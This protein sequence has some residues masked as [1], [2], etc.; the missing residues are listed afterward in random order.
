M[1]LLPDVILY[2]LQ[3]LVPFQLIFLLHLQTVSA[4]IPARRPAA[5]KRY[6]ITTKKVKKKI[7]KL[8]GNWRKV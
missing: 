8:L 7:K 6:K 3:A 2:D 1:C 5:E 4:Y